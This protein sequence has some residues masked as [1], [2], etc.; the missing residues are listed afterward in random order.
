[1]FVWQNLGY[2]FLFVTLAS[3]WRRL[4]STECNLGGAFFF[5][6]VTTKPCLGELILDVVMLMLWGCM[7]GLD[8]WDLARHAALCFP[9]AA[10]RVKKLC[11]LSDST[12]LDDL[13]KGDCAWRAP[14]YFA[15]ASPLVFIVVELNKLIYCLPSGS[16]QV[17]LL[18]FNLRFSCLASCHSGCWSNSCGWNK[19]TGTSNTVQ[20]VEYVYVCVAAKGWKSPHAVQI[21]L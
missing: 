13:G 16:D 5:L 7:E 11:F 14:C 8:E 3:R 18:S 1:M 17:L 20:R 21:I 12:C 2:P 9:P 15:P 19:M 10:A 6:L 4:P